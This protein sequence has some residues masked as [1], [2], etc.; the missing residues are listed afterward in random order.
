M[1][2]IPRKWSTGPPRASPDE[3]SEMRAQNA[4]QRYNRVESLANR[5]ERLDSAMYPRLYEA[6]H[7][8]P[9][10][11]GESFEEAVEK[12]ERQLQAIP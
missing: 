9:S 10:L 6:L 7:L 8:L 2:R 12:L 1:A 3:R 5:I 4:L 11:T